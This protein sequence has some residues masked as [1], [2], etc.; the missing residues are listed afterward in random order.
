MLTEIDPNIYNNKVGGEK[1]ITLSTLYYYKR[2]YLLN[3]DITV[4]Y[5]NVKEQECLS[6]SWHLIQWVIANI[7]ICF[8]FQNCEER[9]KYFP[10]DVWIV[11]S[12]IQKRNLTLE[13]MIY[14]FHV[15]EPTWEQHEIT[16]FASNAPTWFVGG[17]TLFRLHI[18][19]PWWMARETERWGI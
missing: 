8:F 2:E 13:A 5:K 6:T 12:S 7:F 11:F 4:S 19:L 16:N 3:N 18:K 14:F 1:W 17:S 9:K 10:V 15:Q